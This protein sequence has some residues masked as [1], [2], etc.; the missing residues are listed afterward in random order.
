MGFYIRPEYLEAIH[1]YYFSIGMFSFMCSIIFGFSAIYSIIFIFLYVGQSSF[2]WYISWYMRRRMREFVVLN[3]LRFAGEH[4]IL[5]LFVGAM[6]FSLW[7]L[8]AF[9]EEGLITS[10]LQVNYFVFFL[11]VVWYLVVRFNAVRVVF[12]VYDNSSM[13]RAKSLM[14]R[15]RELRRELFTKTLMTNSQ[16]RNYRNGSSPE[17]DE[18]LLS[19]WKDRRSPGLLKRIAELEVA[20]CSLFVARLRDYV[21][22]NESDVMRPTEIE[23][24]KVYS[25]LIE[26]YV[27]SSMEYE[28]QVASKLQ[29]E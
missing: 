5:T 15:T 1:Y 17:I 18:M 8:N 2:S 23:T 25:Q 13:E 12:D 28:K 22:R 11:A 9:N 20:L 27:R 3:S 24:V 6:T 10:I 21:K 19:M 16:V 4:M 29:A 14:I 26:E 7:Y